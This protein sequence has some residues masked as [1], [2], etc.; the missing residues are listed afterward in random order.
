MLVAHKRLYYAWTAFNL[1]YACSLSIG[2]YLTNWTIRQACADGIRTYDFIHGDPQFHTRRS[3]IPTVLEYGQPQCIPGCSRQ[4]FSGALPDGSSFHFVVLTRVESLRLLR[5]RI[6]RTLRSLRRVAKGPQKH[7]KKKSPCSSE[8]GTGT[9]T[10]CRYETQSS[11]RDYAELQFW[12][13]CSA[14]SQI[15]NHTHTHAAE[16]KSARGRDRLGA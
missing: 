13:K 5:A 2:Q 16:Q 8:A 15:A 11:A 14:S 4:M 7:I 3:S 10:L 9:H 12:L 1:E 6:R